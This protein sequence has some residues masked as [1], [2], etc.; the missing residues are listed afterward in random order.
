MRKTELVIIG[1]V[2]GLA[3][4]QATIQAQAATEEQRAKFRDYYRKET[5][6]RWEFAPGR[7][8]FAAA[9]LTNDSFGE[10]VLLRLEKGNVQEV[11]RGKLTREQIPRST[12]E[13]IMG[14]AHALVQ[15]GERR[16]N[17]EVFDLVIYDMVNQP[18]NRL[19]EMSRVYNLSMDM[20]GPAE[21]LLWQKHASYFN[22]LLPP[23]KYNYFCIV[24]DEQLGRYTFDFHLR[25][26]PFTS[27]Q[28][29][30]LNNRA[31]QMYCEGD[32]KGALAK[33]ND[34]ALIAE[35]YQSV[36]SR[37]RRLVQRE[38]EVL[39]QRP[40]PGVTLGDGGDVADQDSLPGAVF[41]ETKLRYLQGEYDLA[42]MSF[43]S[44][45]A[46]YRPDDLA[47]MGMAFAR[48]KDYAELQRITRVLVE[49]RYAGL[50]PYYEEVSRIL[51][52]NR[53]MSQLRAYLKVLERVEPL[54]PTLNFLKAAVLADGGRYAFAQ[55][56]LDTYLSH[57]SDE[58]YEL[59]EV[60]EFLYEMAML[61]GDEATASRVFERLMR[62]PKRDLR[63][64]AYL[65]NFTG[66]PHT[67]RVQVSP[68]L[69][70]GIEVPT[71]ARLKQFLPV[72]PGS[73]PQTPRNSSGESEG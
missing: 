61:N 51:F 52:Y 58:R 55:R 46:H 57:V 41:D 73:P 27:D 20:V 49:N 17:D 30:L 44:S 71:G 22:R 13:F 42:V 4:L 16:G 66:K 59:S 53:D 31:V 56:M 15:V 39:A 26:V 54:S 6:V 18:G 34:A 68:N 3:A 11:R 25:R 45:G 36:I 37:N 69:G 33:F 23:F 70:K 63:A 64:I 72:A 7:L 48:K 24:Y 67:E 28:G 1:L 50:T 60:R 29:V 19:F 5:V 8:P 40:A 62:A 14:G 65:L 43:G 38:M 47:I 32:L 21:L 9:V 10:W 12:V 35:T 2:I